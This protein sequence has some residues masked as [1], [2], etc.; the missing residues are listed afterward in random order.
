MQIVINVN[1]DGT[2]VSS[3]DGQ[4]MSTA[5]ASRPTA[6]P[7]SWW[8]EA[9]QTYLNHTE[10]F[11]RN[12]QRR[13]DVTK[14]WLGGLLKAAVLIFPDLNHTELLSEVQMSIQPQGSS[15]EGM[16]EIVREAPTATE[17]EEGVAPGAAL[18]FTDR[19]PTRVDL[20]RATDLSA[21]GDADY[22][23]DEGSAQD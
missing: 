2:T 8:V 13:A 5:P 11:A 10:A 22:D 19:E 21:L 9:R 7:E 4:Q 20:S 12:D 16:G 17:L 14:Q 3:T 23:V 1:D 18:L 6:L 15:W